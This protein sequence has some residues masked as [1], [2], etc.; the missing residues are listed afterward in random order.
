MTELL[1]KAFRL[2]SKLPQDLQDQLAAELLQEL[3]DEQRWEE[4]L[5]ASAPE[6]ERLADQALEEY[7]RGST[8]EQ[9]ID[10][11]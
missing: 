6:L 4:T 9:G 11:L 10:E 3:A 2:A 8:I 5:S 7:R 1:E